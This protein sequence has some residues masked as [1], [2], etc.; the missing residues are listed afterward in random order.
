MECWIQW[1]AMMISSAL[2][3]SQLRVSQF[4]I[5]TSGFH[6]H[7]HNWPWNIDR[8]V[9][10]RNFLFLAISHAVFLHSSNYFRFFL[11]PRCPSEVTVA[12]T[13]IPKCD[14]H[15]ARFFLEASNWA[16]QVFFHSIFLPSSLIISKDAIVSFFDHHGSSIRSQIQALSQPK[17]QMAV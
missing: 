4:Q 1:W 16:L 8:A 14:E 3:L 2:V 7:G 5:V 15:V 17:P 6:G 11:F 13:I 10:V 12:R 9:Q